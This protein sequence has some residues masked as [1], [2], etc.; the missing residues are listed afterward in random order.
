MSYPD[1]LLVRGPWDPADVRATWLSEP[2]APE[3]EETDEADRQL[4]ALRRRG[5]PAHDGLAARLVSYSADP[6][7]LSLRLQPARWALRLLDHG[8]ASSCSALCVVRSAGGEW[9][10]GRRAAWLATWASRW[11]L[12]AGGAVEVDE[13][14]A[15]TLARELLEEWSVVPERLTVEALVQAPSGMILVIGQAWLADGAEVVPDHEHDEF[16]WWP[17]DVERWPSEADVALRTTAAL[18]TG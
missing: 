9:L 13:N 15:Q 2:F 12:G 10:A 8:A 6:G 16:A 14:P 18:L 5:S 11:A 1:G 4:E 3:Q 17:A 7:S